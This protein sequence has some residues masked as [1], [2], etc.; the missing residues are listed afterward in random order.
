MP[1]LY[2]SIGGIG[3]RYSLFRPYFKGIC[4]SWVAGSITSLASFSWKIEGVYFGTPTYQLMSFKPT[5]FLPN[6]NSYTIDHI[7]TD[8]Y[9][10]NA[11]GPPLPTLAVNAQWVF[12]PGTIDIYLSLDSLGFPDIYYLD[13]PPAPRR[14]PRPG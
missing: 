1:V 3:G 7:L 6:T 2:P 14:W 9:Y 11:G 8:Y 4:S 12:K 13:L 5:F 10:V